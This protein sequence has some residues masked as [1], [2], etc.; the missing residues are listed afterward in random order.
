MP[1]FLIARGHTDMC[2]GVGGK[3]HP[4]GIVSNH[5]LEFAVVTDIL[6]QAKATINEEIAPQVVPRNR[7]LLDIRQQCGQLVDRCVYLN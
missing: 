5:T 1:K 3:N 6:Y 7:I 4:P 2:N